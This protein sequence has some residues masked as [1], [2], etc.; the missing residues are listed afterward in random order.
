VGNTLTIEQAAERVARAERKRIAAHPF[1]KQKGKVPP[2]VSG[3][4]RTLAARAG[5]KPRPPLRRDSQNNGARRE[6]RKART[7]SSMTSSRASPARR[8]AG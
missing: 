5:N 8:S 1:V 3:A 4:A 2:A 7:T 6:E